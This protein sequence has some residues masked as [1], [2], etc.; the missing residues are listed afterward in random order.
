MKLVINISHNLFE[1]LVKGYDLSKLGEKELRKSVS[2][3]KSFSTTL[4][5]IRAEIMA[6]GH[7]RTKGEL[8]NGYLVQVIDIIDKYKTESEE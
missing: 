2:H 3:G 1:S 4:D 5:Q 8:P 6:I 7:W